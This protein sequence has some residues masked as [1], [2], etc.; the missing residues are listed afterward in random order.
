MILCQGLVCKNKKN[1]LSIL[2]KIFHINYIKC[3]IRYKCLRYSIRSTV[4]NDKTY[5]L[6][7]PYDFKTRWCPDFWN[8]N[9]K[10][11]SFW[12]RLWSWK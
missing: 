8:K 7:L 2:D 6:H 3:P 9:Y 5:Y 4:Y 10:N 11:N 1:K 12:M